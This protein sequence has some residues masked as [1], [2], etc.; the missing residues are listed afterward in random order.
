MRTSPTNSLSTAASSTSPDTPKNINSEL[1]AGLPAHARQLNP[2]RTALYVPAVLRPT[3]RSN[4]QFPPTP[5]QSNN[6]SVDNLDD[7]GSRQLARVSTAE[8]TRSRKFGLGRVQEDDFVAEEKWA[9]VTGPPSKDHWQPDTSTKSCTIPP[10]RKTFTLTER[11]HHCR[12]CGN[13]FCAEHSTFNLPLDQDARFHP[14]G[15]YSRAC[16][17]CWSD[18]KEWELRRNSRSNSDVSSKT[19]ATPVVGIARAHGMGEDGSVGSA[20]AGKA[21]VGSYSQSVP[22]DWQWSTF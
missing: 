21:D 4:R 17:H 19:P 14:D 16:D 8:S 22:R 20:G 1:M 12:R 7:L 6:A 11:R 15:L 2:P 13:I 18:Y 10:C 9:K 3:E 5:P